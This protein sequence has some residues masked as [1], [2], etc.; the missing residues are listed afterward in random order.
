MGRVKQTEALFELAGEPARRRS[1]PVPPVVTR[2]QWVAGE[3]EKRYFVQ[4]KW[5]GEPTICWVLHNPGCRGNNQ[6][7]NVDTDSLMAKI[8]SWSYRWGFGGMLLVALYPVCATSVDDAIAWRKR[9]RLTD[10]W[11]HFEQAAIVAGAMAN[12]LKCAVRVAA[13]GRLDAEAHEDLDLW[14]E[15]F[16]GKAPAWCL[17][18]SKWGDPLLPNVRGPLR[19][20]PDTVL[21]PFVYPVPVARDLPNEKKA[22]EIA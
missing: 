17:G 2:G 19:P 22:T 6:K 13:W 9:N 14:L 7:M 11:E 12:R 4:Q 10:E 16:N 21:Q 15:L 20:L 5:S 18:T 1:G 3:P 8:A